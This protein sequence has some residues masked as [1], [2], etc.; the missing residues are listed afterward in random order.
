MSARQ[1]QLYPHLQ[2]ALDARVLSTNE[3]WM[4][5]DVILISPPGCRV[6]LSQEFEGPINKMMLFEAEPLND[7][8]I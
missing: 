5:Q 8:P 6:E 4:L 2:E 1:A 7:L 3:A